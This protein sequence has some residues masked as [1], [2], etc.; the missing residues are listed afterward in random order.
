[1]TS[2]IHANKTETVEQKMTYF[3]AI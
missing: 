3:Q 2:S 1:M